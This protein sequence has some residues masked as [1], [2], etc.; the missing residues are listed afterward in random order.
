MN[1]PSS[2]AKADLYVG[3]PVA[4]I[5]FANDSLNSGMLSSDDE[6]LPFPSDDEWS[7]LSS[8]SLLFLVLS[9]LLDS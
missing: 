6:G 1:F 2:V 8:E 7:P 4:F 3:F 9:S 5:K